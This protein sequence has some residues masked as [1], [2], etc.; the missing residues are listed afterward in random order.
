M[1]H[2]ATKIRTNEGVKSLFYAL[3]GMNID[4]PEGMRFI[5]NLND[6]KAKRVIRFVFDNGVEIYSSPMTKFYTDDSHVVYAKDLKEGDLVQGK[7]GT[8]K[9]S[10]VWDVMFEDKKYITI[11]TDSLYENYYVYDS[12]LVG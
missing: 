8:V 1:L 7:N 4:T 11:K 3:V 9:L 2:P 6:Y 12:I 5:T 10:E